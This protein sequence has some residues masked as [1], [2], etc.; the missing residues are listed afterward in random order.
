MQ[1]QLRNPFYFL[2]LVVGI[3]FLL[4]TSSY[5]VVAVRGLAPNRPGSSAASVTSGPD[6]G[7]LVDEYG[8]AALMTE[9]VLLAAMTVAAIATDQYWMNRGLTDNAR[10]DQIQEDEDST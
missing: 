10:L 3:L 2:L 7:H 8:F 6:F 1:K 9:L 4:T 5:A